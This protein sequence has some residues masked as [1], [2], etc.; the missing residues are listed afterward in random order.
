MKVKAEKDD[1]I[2]VPKLHQ[3]LRL[4]Q[5]LSETDLFSPDG[6]FAFLEETTIERWKNISTPTSH[7]N[8]DA[9]LFQLGASVTMATAAN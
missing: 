5:V 9:V 2:P 4:Q 3:P 8:Q 6:S 7:V 1:K